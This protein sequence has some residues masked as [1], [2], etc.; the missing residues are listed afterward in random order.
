MDGILPLKQILQYSQRKQYEK[1]KNR[2]RSYSSRADELRLSLSSLSLTE[3]E[4]RPTPFVNQV[5][6]K[7]ATEN[8]TL[9]GNVYSAVVAYI[10]LYR[11]K[12]PERRSE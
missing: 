11:Y 12:Q 6:R 7:G 1:K 2:R 3:S 10:Y 5:E 8:V 4:Q 9:D